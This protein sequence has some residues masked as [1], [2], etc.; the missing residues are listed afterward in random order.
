MTTETVTR[1]EM[2]EALRKES[3]RT[4]KGMADL[5]RGLL[6]L[7]RLEPMAEM[8]K[9]RLFVKSCFGDPDRI[10][11]HM[12]NT[13]TSWRRYAR[14]AGCHAPRVGRSDPAVYRGFWR[15]ARL[16]AFVPWP[17]NTPFHMRQSAGSCDG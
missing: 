14:E 12:C 4:E 6:T 16:R 7:L 2:A 17:K 11:G 13:S 5:A 10:R 3:E 8:G 9:T 15:S 1:Q